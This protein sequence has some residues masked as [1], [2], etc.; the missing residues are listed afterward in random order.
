MIK[1]IFK[2][3]FFRIKTVNILIVNSMKNKHRFNSSQ[4]TQQTTKH[5]SLVFSKMSSSVKCVCR[6]LYLNQ[7]FVKSIIA[8]SFNH[9]F[10]TNN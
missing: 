8:Y 7:Y 9:N 10:K 5:D 2:N 6:L 1:Y 4:E 3:M